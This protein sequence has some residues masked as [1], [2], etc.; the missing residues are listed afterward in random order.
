[1]QSPVAAGE[2]VEAE[3]LKAVAFGQA[4]VRPQITRV[5]Q[6]G[7]QTVHQLL[8]RHATPCTLSAAGQ[9]RPT[10]EGQW[11]WWGVSV[12][13][14]DLVARGEVG[15][16]D[17]EGLLDDV[18]HLAPERTRGDRGAPRLQLTA[19]P[20]IQHPSIHQSQ[21]SADHNPTHP[22][23]INQPINHFSEVCRR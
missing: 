7:V 1:M 3:E 8:T 5:V 6:L 4:A 9:D 21:P 17:E 23:I 20:A 16:E 10:K 11:E 19:T 14:F 18:V 13:A 2:D 12:V 15:A 22:P